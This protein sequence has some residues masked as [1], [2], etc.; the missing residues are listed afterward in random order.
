MFAASAQAVAS[1]TAAGTLKIQGSNDPDTVGQPT[2]WS[3]ITNATATVAGAGAVM[4]QK[5]DVCYQWIR[6]VFTSTKVGVQTVTTVADVAGS[7]NSKY[8]LLDSASGGTKY[9]VWMNINSAGVDPNIA[10]R[11]GV[12]IAAATGASAS[13]VATAV[14]SGIDALAL[15]VSGAVGAV[16]TVTNSAGGPFVPAVDGAAPTGF[17]FAVTAPTGTISVQLKTLGS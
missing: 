15:F 8:F 2:N 9:Y 1:G 3:D 11:T 16:V 4:V 13:T 7:L 12:E 14:A 17:S 6:S 5:F 10:G